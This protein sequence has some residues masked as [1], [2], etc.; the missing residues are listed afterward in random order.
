LRELDK[1]DDV[2]SVMLAGFN[3]EAFERF[4]E[5]HG[6]RFKGIYLQA[7]QRIAS[8][9]P[10]GELEDLEYFAVDWNQRAETLW[11]MKRNTALRGLSLMGFTRLH[12]LDCLATAPSLEELRF[13]NELWE[14]WV[15]DTLEPL[16]RCRRLRALE[17]SIKKLVDGRIEP[18]AEIPLL[19]QLC[20]P[21]PFFM[22]EQV[23]WLKARLG[24]RVVS[25]RLAPFVTP[26][27][28]LEQDGKV[29]DTV[30]IGKRKPLLSSRDDAERIA[31]YVARFHAL[32]T[33][34]TENPDL[35]PPVIKIA[36]RKSKKGT[37][38]GSK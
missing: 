23:A 21:P 7:S 1:H 37:K 4:I 2:E 24:E 10:L 12:R 20:F 25:D 9:A 3:Q 15:L 14:S 11:D 13:G 18:L 38:T 34:Y 31:R 17:F 33:E 19:E 35:A 30:I 16:S 6:R 5:D 22:T 32:V 26:A 36:R 8:L 28:P 29:F 27:S